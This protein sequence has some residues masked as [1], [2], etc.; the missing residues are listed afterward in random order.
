MDMQE[1][2]AKLAAATKELTEEERNALAKMFQ[3][4]QSDIT[5]ED[6]PKVDYTFAASSDET[7]IPD[8]MTPR[9]DALKK[10]YLNAKPTIS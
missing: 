10:Q 5:K 8:G 4:V 7:G 3:T 1:F 2:T 6:D 9:L